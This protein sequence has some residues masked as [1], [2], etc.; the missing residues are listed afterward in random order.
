[1][2][3]SQALSVAMPL[4]SAPTEAAV[5]LVLWMRSLAHSETRTR[6]ESMPS[7]CAATCTCL[8]GRERER[9]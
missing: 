9:K 8:R 1:M 5:G 3:C 6:L 4:R 2:I 7:D